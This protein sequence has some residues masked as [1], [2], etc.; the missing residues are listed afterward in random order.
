[1]TEALLRVGEVHAA[2]G[3]S[4]VLH[5]MSLEAHQREVVSL[6]GRNGPGKST[7]LKREGMTIVLSEQNL[8]FAAP[9]ADRAY[10][11]E[12]GEFRLARPMRELLADESIRRAY[13]S[14]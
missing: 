7:A 9:P 13:L 6:L 10:I 12:K 4:R 1:L 5:G 14:V 8:K 2:Y 11:V 3:P